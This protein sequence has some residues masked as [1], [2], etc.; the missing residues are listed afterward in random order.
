MTS[1][2]TIPGWRD[3]SGAELLAFSQSNPQTAAP[4]PA[5]PMQKW[6]RL[7]D[8]LMRVD[9]VFAG[10]IPTIAADSE[11]PVD[12][13][14]KIRGLLSE[15]EENPSAAI[16]TNSDEYAPLFAWLMGKVSLPGAEIAKFYALGGGRKYPLFATEAEATAAQAAAILAADRLA[17]K[18]AI[19]TRAGAA[20]FAA[21]ASYDAGDG[22]EAITAA[23]EAAW[24]AG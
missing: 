14:R 6:L 13:A 17:A 2:E 7:N 1:I 18:S 15:F 16:E 8:L 23:G 9:G 21:A 5:A 12:M 4:V 11:T 24:E 10:L 20:S 19:E 22:A 3:K